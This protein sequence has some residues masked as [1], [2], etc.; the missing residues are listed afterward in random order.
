MQY[1]VICK[2]MLLHKNI[3]FNEQLVRYLADDAQSLVQAYALKKYSWLTENN[4][5]KKG[6][7]SNVYGLYISPLRPHERAHSAIAEDVFGKDTVHDWHGVTLSVCIKNNFHRILYIHADSAGKSVGTLPGI[8]I[9]LSNTFAN[10]MIG[11]F[12][13]TRNLNLIKISIN[14]TFYE[15]ALCTQQTRA[16]SEQEYTD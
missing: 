12:K 6:L 13:Y 8:P 1:W 4:Y 10:N 16:I 11:L 3:Q 7:W 15:Y 5:V 9:E 14:H 2:H